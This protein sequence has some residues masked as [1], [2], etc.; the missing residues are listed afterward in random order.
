MNL[1]NL[2][3]KCEC[4]GQM[5][6]IKTKWKGLEVRGWRCK[7]CKEEVINPIDAQKALDIEKARKENKLKVKLRR[8]GKSDVVTIPIIIKQIEGFKTGQELE[9]DIKDGKLMLMS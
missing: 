5:E 1:E 8:V 9:W 4:N 3:L 7:K 6:R 2:K